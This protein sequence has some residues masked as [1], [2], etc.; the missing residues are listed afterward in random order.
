MKVVG[1]VSKGSF[2]YPSSVWSVL[3]A[4]N[5]RLCGLI[6]LQEGGSEEDLEAGR[7][8]GRQAGREGEREGRREKDGWLDRWRD[9]GEAKRQGS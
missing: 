4:C 2:H 6:Y 8:G 9:L 1:N 3:A 5:D 7:Q